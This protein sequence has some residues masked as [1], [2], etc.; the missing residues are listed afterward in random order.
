M[1]LDH[2]LSRETWPQVFEDLDLAKLIDC[3]RRMFSNVDVVL[4]E[5][6]CAE[7]VLLGRLRSI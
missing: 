7:V 6:E 1:R 2:L 5:G 3:E 4:V